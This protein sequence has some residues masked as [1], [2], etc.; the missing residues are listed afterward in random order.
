METSDIVKECS[1]R[2]LLSRMRVIMNNPF[3]GLL[4]MHVDFGIDDAMPT[5]Y[6][7]GSKIRFN[8]SF[9]KNLS[10]G[11][12][13]FVLMHEIMHIV[14]RHCTRGKNL[15]RLR[16]NIACD[17]VVN[18]N[19]LKSM[20]EDISSITISKFGVSMH[21]TPNGDEGYNYT[22]EEVYL[23]LNSKTEVLKYV[24]N[25]KMNSFD[26][27]DEWQ[28]EGGVDEEY[29]DDVWVK[30]IQDAVIAVENRVTSKNNGNVPKC[31]ER[32]LKTLNAPK[33]DWRTVLNNF[34]SEEVCDYT[35]SPPDRRYDG[36]FYLPDFN[37][38]ELQV[39]NILF[40]IDT[41]GSMSDKE[42]LEMYSE[43]NGAVE[44]FNG[45]LCGY[46]G[47][48]DAEVVEPK[49]FTN[50]SEFKIIKAYGGG[51]TS[52]INV[53][54]YVKEKMDEDMPSAIIILTDGYATFP[55]KDKL[56]DIPVLW[57]INN[58]TVK[59]PFGKVLRI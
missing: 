19:V 10:D 3:Y 46:L 51:G 32:M 41:S 5:A 55:P 9:M 17:I 39:K 54:N 25:G 27:H 4:L 42:V 26:N 45:M 38:V 23:M 37:G 29:N 33:I 47:F 58:N 11:E 7:D 2:L 53:F 36:D 8:S 13:D 16:Y 14:L 34:I 44:Q 43:V 12:L 21:L 28:L 52:F 6:T 57:V 50:E 49:L 20:D 15:E 35:F 30:R 22:A 31:I 40:M 18:S 1:K 24:I 48:F 56:P 59:P